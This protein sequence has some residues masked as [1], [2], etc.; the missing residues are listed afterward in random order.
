MAKR[1]KEKG[2][3]E[4][5]EES[6]FFLKYKLGLSNFQATT[7]IISVILLPFS[8]ILGFGENRLLSFTILFFAVIVLDLV[9]ISYSIHVLVKNKKATENSKGLEQQKIYNITQI[10]EADILSGLD[11]E[12]LV[13]RIF[14]EKGYKTEITKMS[15]DGGADIIAEKGQDSICIQAKRRARAI[16]KQAVYEAY[17]AQKRYSVKR[18]CIATNNTL[19]E[20]AMNFA[21]DYNVEILDR[22]KLKAI[23]RDQKVK[24][25]VPKTNQQKPL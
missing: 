8:I 18:A 2:F 5:I 12:R 11:F 24:C 22:Y 7:V 17:F 10:E 19:T 25:S 3:N 6:F 9:C 23:L 20:Q 4:I 14:I 16:N 21:K 13:E 1:K 15:F